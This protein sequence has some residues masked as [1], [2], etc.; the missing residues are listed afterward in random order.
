L[1]KERKHMQPSVILLVRVRDTDGSRKYL[2][3]Q[4]AYE[5]KLKGTYYLRYRYQGKRQWEPVGKDKAAAYAAK[6][7]KQQWLAQ[8]QANQKLGIEVVSPVPEHRVVITAAMQAFLERMWLHRSPKTA[9]EFEHMLTAFHAACQKTYL[10]EISGEDL[11]GY[12]ASLRAQGLADRTVAN[13][14]ARVSCFLRANGITGLVAPHEWPDCDERVPEAYTEH[15]LQQ[16]FAAARPFERLVF[17]FFLGSGAREA[18]VAN[19]TWRDINFDDKTFTVRSK[20]KQGFRPKD[21]AE[22]RVPLPD[23][24]VAA[25]KKH[26]VANPNSVYLFPN[27]DDQPNGHFLRMLKKLAKRAGLNCGECVQVGEHKRQSCLTAP[28]CGKFELHKFRRSFATLH[29]EAG[30][31]ARQIQQWLGHSD[32][33]TTLRYLAIA[34][35]RSPKTRERVNRSFDFLGPKSM[36]AGVGAD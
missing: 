25:L 14:F 15:E 12:A 29:H 2:T 32:L 6:L 23:S 19:A 16:L 21:K 35:D 9:S 7:R 34:D 3:V 10:D 27:K 30:V 17:E 1:T 26:R 28:V 4:E 13:R 11:L 20:P 24:L 22:R 33:S 8:M 31:P 36:A 18:E 5:K